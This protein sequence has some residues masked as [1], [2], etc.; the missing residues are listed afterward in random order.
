[1]PEL[2]ASVL[3]AAL[4][5][6]MAMLVLMLLR[7]RYFSFPAQ[8]PGDYAQTGPAFDP[9]RVLNGSID[10]EGVIFGPTGRAVSRFVMRME[11]RWS[12]GTGILTEDFTYDSGRSQ[13]REWRLSLRPDGKLSAEA[14]DIVGTGEGLIAGATLRLSYRLKLPEDA[15]GHVLDVIDWL[16]LMQDGTIMNR[17]QMGRFGVPLAELIATM[18]PARTSAPAADPAA[19]PAIAVPAYV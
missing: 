2:S 3:W 16:Y 15:G 13:H 7:T 19:D 5:G 17:S 14:D 10:S 11:G 1:M 6:A 12:G 4:A 8:R 18:R 9:V